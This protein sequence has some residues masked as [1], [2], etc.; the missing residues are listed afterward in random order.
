M[1]NAK[2]ERSRD[3]RLWGWVLARGI[4]K[5]MTPGKR[6]GDNGAAQPPGTA[7][8][9]RHCPQPGQPEGQ[10]AGGRDEREDLPNRDRWS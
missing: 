10:G 2:Y 6:S 5:A 9:V 1:V 3:N 8:K 4:R 7:W